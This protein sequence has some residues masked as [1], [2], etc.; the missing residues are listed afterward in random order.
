MI[1]F[2]QFQCVEFDNYIFACETKTFPCGCVNFNHANSNQIV[3]T[4]AE[5]S[6]VLGI[7]AVS[8]IVESPRVVEYLAYWVEN[9]YLIIQ[10]L[11]DKWSWLLIRRRKSNSLQLLFLKNLELAQRVSGVPRFFIEKCLRE[12]QSHSIFPQWTHYFGML[13]LSTLFGVLK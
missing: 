1:V 9:H 13:G 7:Q 4:L 8:F 6:C 10:L 2:L 11:N 3:M 12:D 5:N